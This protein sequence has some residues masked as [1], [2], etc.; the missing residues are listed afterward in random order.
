MTLSSDE[1]LLRQIKYLPMA[2]IGIFVVLII[3][4]MLNENRIS[5]EEDISSLKQNF[6]SE[7]KK[8]IQYRITN[9]VEQIEYERQSTE[10]ILRAS[11]KERVEDAIAIAQNIYDNNPTLSQE[12][13]AK[14]ITDALRGIRFN[15]GRGYFFIYKLDGTNVMHPI[16]KNIEGEMLW[17]LQDTRGSFVIRDLSK[18]AQHKGSAFHRWWW[19]KP[20]YLEQEFDKIGYVSHFEPLDWFI[21]TGEYVV[22]VEQDIQEKLLKRISDYR[23]GDGGYVYIMNSKGALLSHPNP[24]LIDVERLDAR[25]SS[26]KLYVKEIVTTA[27]EGGGFLEYYS[28][29]TPPGLSSSHKLSY[30]TYLHIGLDYWYRYLHAKCRIFLSPKTKPN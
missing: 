25:D 18:L 11:V 4:V 23:Y 20:G 16:L 15:Q 8:S 1:K 26:G 12:Q 5:L 2:I 28:S 29:Y 17:D 22:D 21:G 9:I 13:V 3:A 14:V 30:V 7:E 24:A 6:Y 19:S 27:N 10:E